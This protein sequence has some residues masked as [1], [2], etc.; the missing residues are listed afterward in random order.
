MTRKDFELLAEFVKDLS[1]N[2]DKSVPLE[3]I[4]RKLA[5]KLRSTNPRFNEDRFLRACGVE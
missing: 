3:T 1:M 5:K 2:H 4:A